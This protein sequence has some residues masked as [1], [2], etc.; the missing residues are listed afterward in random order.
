M[1]SVLNT[2]ITTQYFNAV[3]VAL[4]YPVGSGSVSARYERID[5]EYRTLGA[6]FFNNDLEN[7]TANAS[8]S[9]FNDK[10]NISAN[11]GVQRDNLNK[12]KTTE[13]QRIVTAVNTTITA[14]EK[15]NMNASYSNFQSFTNIR[16]QFD[17]I[18]EVGQFDNI[19]TLNYRQISEN[20][21]LGINYTIK[22]T[23]SKAYSAT[24]NL[25]YQNAKNLQNDV[26][27]D[28]AS[29]AFYNATAAYNLGFPKSTLQ[30][31]L[32]ANSSFNRTQTNEN[33]IFGPTLSISKQF[34][35]KTLRSNFSSAYNASYTNGNQGNTVLN[36]RLGNSYTWKERHN[37]NL[38]LLALLRQNEANNATDFTATLGYSYSFD[39]I[40]TKRKLV[41]KE[42]AKKQ[43]NYV[44]FRYSDV[45]YSGSM[46]SVTRQITTVYETTALRNISPSKRDVLEELLAITAQQDAPQTYKNS[47]IQFLKQVYNYSAFEKAF[48][49]ATFNVIQNIAKD[50]ASVD[51]QLERAYARKQTKLSKTVNAESKQALEK[52]LEQ[53]KE[54][55]LTHRWMQQQ[56]RVISADA[57]IAN[58]DAMLQ[59]F[60][61]E[62]FD[63]VFERYEQQD[64]EKIE[65]Y[66]ETQ[67]ISFYTEKAKILVGSKSQEL[68]K[69]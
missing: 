65:L 4:S 31:S 41:A 15:L 37:F 40:K 68:D 63:A 19:D 24:L 61:K 1:S 27:Q 26:E 36:F 9:I 59:T 53:F 44:S 13:L 33:L 25:L 16:N 67:I 22:K 11:V 28:D 57:K 39:R 47:A 66:L 14:S 69:L 30:V 56:F 35:D 64:S 49:A 20:I 48:N 43:N 34:F 32:A 6:Y 5:P 46:P 23:E 52:E 54:G 55:I 62:H 2:N 51:A 8:Q 29:N 10:V 60:K 42:E 7:V 21:N 17:F 12:A 18:N 45:T 50:M 58:A 38:N 3:N